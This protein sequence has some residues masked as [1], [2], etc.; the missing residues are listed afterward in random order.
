MT[1]LPEEPREADLKRQCM[2]FFPHSFISSVLFL[3]FLFTSND[4]QNHT[5]LS[6]SS[7]WDSLYFESCISDTLKTKYNHK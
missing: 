5:V 7:F 4:A 2:F 1:G 6:S 3:F